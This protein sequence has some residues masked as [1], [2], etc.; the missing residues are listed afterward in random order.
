[1]ICDSGLWKEDRST[2]PRALHKRSESGARN[3]YAGSCCFAV[4]F[5]H[6]VKIGRTAA[7]PRAHAL[8]FGTWR[9]L[10]LTR[11]LLSR[12]WLTPNTPQS[13]WQV[14][15][16]SYDSLIDPFLSDQSVKAVSLS[17]DA[18]SAY[19]TSAFRGDTLSPQI[20]SEVSM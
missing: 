6:I 5:F 3:S 8:K 7:L 17:W 1:M 9:L 16:S 4:I 2:Q 11:D 12:L 19:V 13:I 20:V 15:K 10:T 14:A 18:C